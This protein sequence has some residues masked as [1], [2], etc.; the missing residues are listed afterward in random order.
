MSPERYTHLLIKACSQTVGERGMTDI[1]STPMQHNGSARC[2]ENYT[3][4]HMTLTL[5]GTK[6]T[7]TICTCCIWRRLLH[8]TLRA[9][10]HTHTNTHIHRLP[11]KGQCL[12]ECAGTAGLWYVSG[13]RPWDTQGRACHRMWGRVWCSSFPHSPTDAGTRDN[14]AH[15]FVKEGYRKCTYNATEW[16]W[17]HMRP[18]LRNSVHSQT[19]QH[20]RHPV[21]FPTSALPKRR[22]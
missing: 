12:C 13:P 15:T 11:F 10:T 2:L 5:T 6:M 22:G 4:G 3:S 9:H 17:K 20:G 16:W 7:S 18:H 14:T 19:R 1:L 21:S 8:A